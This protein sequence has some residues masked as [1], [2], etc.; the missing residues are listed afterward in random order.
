MASSKSK[1]D[2]I[3]I[4]ASQQYENTIHENIEDDTI[5]LEVSQQFKVEFAFQF[6]FGFSIDFW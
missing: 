1:D 6:Q 2:Q 4:E 3:I 5:Y